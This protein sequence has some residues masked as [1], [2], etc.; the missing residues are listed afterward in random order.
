MADS[1]MA[2]KYDVI[3]VGA[4]IG[5]LITGAYLSKSERKKILVL[6]KSEEF[7]G[8]GITIKGEDINNESKLKRLLADSPS[9]RIFKTMPELSEIM[10]RN[11]LEGYRFDV[12][13]HAITLATKGRLGYILNDLG[14]TLNI[15]PNMGAGF[16]YEGN[17]LDFSKGYPWMSKEDYQELHRLAKEMITLSAIEAES[18]DD[19]SIR[20]WLS[21]RTDNQ[22]AMDFHEIMSTLNC[23]INNPRQISAGDS[24]KITQQVIKEGGGMINGGFGLIDDSELPGYMLIARKLSEVIKAND[25]EIWTNCPVKEIVVENLRATGVIIKRNG[26]SMKLTTPIVISNLPITQLF[27]IVPEKHFERDFID[28]VKAFWSAGAVLGT[29]GLNRSL[30]DIN[31]F[32]IIPSL[33]TAGNGF[34]FDVRAVLLQS[35]NLSPSKAPEGKHLMETISFIHGEEIRNRKKVNLHVSSMMDFLKSNFSG[36][37]E[38]IEWGIFMASDALCPVAEAPRQVGNSRPDVRSPIKGLYFVGETVKCW[39]STVDAAAHSALLCLSAI[40]GK[41]YLAILP[42]HQR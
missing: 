19:I 23:S 7:G 4:G 27:S 36:F 42:E 24:I 3:I 18:Y 20:E 40:V 12:G 8:R 11:L 21:Q 35:T 10:S 6:E 38:S 1:S 15:V 33:I 9:A 28:R 14:I 13:I 26:K 39:G 31:G 32:V 25:G 41:D 16:F 29:F 17:I 22:A 5:G 37:E 2:K 30:I 34:D